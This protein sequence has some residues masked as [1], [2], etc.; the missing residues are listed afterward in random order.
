M[1][2]TSTLLLA[3]FISMASFAVPAQSKLSITVIGHQNI[4]ILVGNN[5]YEGQENSIVLSNLQPGSHII[6][7]YS[8][9][10]SR[11]KSVWGNKRS[12]QLIYS[13]TVYLRPGYFTRITVDSYGKA[14]VDERV[15]RQNRRDDDWSDDRYRDGDDRYNGRDD[16]SR[17]RDD[18]YRRR[19]DRYSEP[20]DRDRRYDDNYNRSAV[21]EQS[22]G[23]IV[24]TLK[25]EYSENSRVVLAKQIIDRNYFTASQVKYM[26]QLF[27]FEHH[28]LDLAKY[29]YRY[30]VD[31]R[32]YF[33]V[34][35]VFTYSHSKDELADYI[36][37]YK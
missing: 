2:T 21:S 29:A 27:P 30:T 13:S 32:N 6:K 12:S 28:K 20:N 19:D 17:R 14:Q 31:Q 18:R 23:S 9:G 34:Y 24:Q 25:R 3:I 35:D 1:K 10:N 15:L 16:H 11:R 26:L 33:S 22:F 36:R 37:R 8:Y 4:Q 5:R 7:V